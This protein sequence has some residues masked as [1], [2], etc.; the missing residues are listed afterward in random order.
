[1][2]PDLCGNVGVLLP[3]AVAVVGIDVVGA[4]HTV[5]RLQHHP[6]VVVRDHVR[7]SEEQPQHV[8]LTYRYCTC[9]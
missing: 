6:A 1:M 2:L 7:V 8:S 4:D 9:R 3:V 5:Y